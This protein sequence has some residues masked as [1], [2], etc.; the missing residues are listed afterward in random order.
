MALKHSRIYQPDPTKPQP[1]GWDME[2]VDERGNAPPGWLYGPNGQI[3]GLVSGDGMVLI[4]VVSGLS[5]EASAATATANTTRLQAALDAG[6]L[7][8]I[9]AQGTYYTNNT[10]YIGDNTQLVIAPGVTFK[11]ASAASGGKKRMLSTQASLLTPTAVTAAWT[12]NDA[13]M[14]VTWAS[15]GLTTQ[16]YV[17][18]QGAQLTGTVTAA[19]KANPCV[20]TSAAHGLNTG[21]RVTFNSD[22]GGMT[23]LNG[24]SYIVTRVTSDTFSLSGL[25]TTTDSSA[26]GTFTSGG[27]WFTIQ[28][29]YNNV[30]RVSQVVDANSFV[31]ALYETPFI[32]PSGSLTAVRCTRNFSVIGGTWDYDTPASPDWPSNG[33]DR[34]CITMFYAANFHVG[35]VVLKNVAKYGLNTM[36][37]AN[38]TCNNIEGDNVAEIFKHYGPNVA[39][40]VRGIYGYSVDDCSTV[41]TREPAAFLYYQ[42]AHGDIINLHISDVNVRNRGG[43][44][45]GG[46]VVYA[47]NH[48]RIVNLTLE[49]VITKTELSPGLKLVNG[50]QTDVGLISSVHLID[51]VFGTKA[52]TNCINISYVEVDEIRLTRTKLEPADLATALF[53][54]NSSTNVET[55]YVE[56]MTFNN[57]SWPTSGQTMFSLAGRVGKFI[58]ERCDIKGAG[59]AIF[60][61]VASTSTLIESLTFR[62]SNF[63]GISS[64]ADIRALCNVHR[65]NCRFANIANG[66]LRIQTATGLTARVYGAGHNTYSSA[67]PMAILSPATAEIY[68]WDCAID[69][70]ALTQLATTVGQ[71]CTSTQAGNEGGLAV[72][73]NVNGTPAWYSLVGGAAGVNAAIT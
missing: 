1:G 24:N 52:A 39:G 8:Q 66:V 17:C 3:L 20:I 37:V 12:T 4:P 56:G 72:R 19:T 47:S 26:F 21:D 13:K 9:L 32:A 16:D 51:C 18:I 43:S 38:Y 45:S 48:D 50:L 58:A 35:N 53:S 28:N 29:E 41:Q 40:T 61:Q 6:G 15:H 70:I 34:H 57:E 46:M 64:V 68:D 11:S 71:F 31:V 7:V 67:V 54:L 27:T 55:I 59:G 60:V 73:G 14:T 63:D 22:V 23:Q 62:D 10:L 30:F 42:A 69:P 33:P 25:T 5:E 49:R 36:G 44:G 65:E 2:H